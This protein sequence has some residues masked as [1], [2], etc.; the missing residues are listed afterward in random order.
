M[1]VPL[2][3]SFFLRKLPFLVLLLIGLLHAGQAQNIRYVK[4]GAT[5]GGASW[6][7]ASGDI[8]LM[9]N[10]LTA[11]PGGGQV[12]IAGG[13]Y[14]PLHL[15][16]GDA[17]SDHRDRAF[18]LK[19][20][21]K[22]YGGF[23]GTEQALNQRDTLSMFSA[24]RQ[25]VLSGNIRDAGGALIYIS[26]HV[27]VS[28]GDVGS[29][30]MDGLVISDG[31]GAGGGSGIIN[32]NGQEIVRG[33][34]AGLYISGSSPRV[35]RVIIRDNKSDSG[36]GGGG[37]FADANSAPVLS[38]VLIYQNEGHTGGG[39][40]S[41]STGIAKLTNVTIA[42]NKA[43]NGAGGGWFNEQSNGVALPVLKNSILHGN[44]AGAGVTGNDIDY[45]GNLTPDYTLVANTFFYHA[46]SISTVSGQVFT[47]AAVGDFTLAATS[48]AINKGNPNTTVSEA[49]HSDLYGGERKR[50]V[51]DLG[52]IE[53]LVSPTVTITPASG[54]V[55][56]T[57]QGAGNFSGNSWANATP[58]LRGAINA[59]GAQQVWV[60]RGQYL[61]PSGQS[62]SM[63]EGVKI[64][65][66]F[67]G[68]E[69]QLTQRNYTTNTT[70][71]KGNGNSVIRNNKNGLTAT[72]SLLDGFTITGGK[73]EKGG[74]IYNEK[75][76]PSVSNCIINAN[77]A[78]HGG[79]WYNDD[80]I[81]IVT[82]CVFSNNT[83]TKEGGGGY[84]NDGIGTFVNCT[85]MD[86]R[87][88]SAQEGG[89][90]GWC[91]YF[92]TTSFSNCLF[93]ENKSS[94][95]G[96]GFYNVHGNPTLS[97]CTFEKNS[98]GSS[99]GGGGWSNYEGNPELTDCIFKENSAYGGG[100]WFNYGGTPGL[101]GCYFKENT[102]KQGGGWYHQD[103]TP[104]LESCSFE[105][106][107][108]S[109]SHG[110]GWYNNTGNPRLKGCSFKENTA[111]NG[112]GWLNFQGTPTLESCNFEKNSA[113]SLVGGGGWLN[114]AGDPELI[115][116][117]FKENTA[118]GGG[119][120]HNYT[121][122]PTLRNCNF[123]KNSALG[124][125]G[126]WYNNSESP[127]LTGCT[128]K[129]NIA[130][131]G[132]G[133][134]NYNGSPTL[135]N[136][137]F[138]KNSALRSDGGGWL[139]YAGNPALE[140]C[141]FKENT[142]LY[143][144]GWYNK[145]GSPMLT[146]CT[147]RENSSDVGG[148]WINLDGTPYVTNCTFEK[149]RAVI[150]GG[151]W[152]N[153]SGSP[154]VV[155]SLFSGNESFLG[156]AWTNHAG[157]PSVTG[158]LFLANQAAQSTKGENGQ[159][160]AW[161]NRGGNFKMVNCT[162]TGNHTSGTLG[163]VL[164]D[165]NNGATPEI[166]N[167]IISGNTIGE[168]SP[169]D[170]DGWG[171]H[172]ATIR[173]SI[174]T[175]N[176]YDGI[177]TPAAQPNTVVDPITGK[178][179]DDSPAINQ[180]DPNTNTSGYAVQAGERDFF[181]NSRIKFGQID[182]GALER[183]RPFAE[184]HFP[185]NTHPDSRWVFY[186][187]KGATG[188]GSGRSFADAIPELAEALYRVRNISD[189]RIYV[190]GGEYKPYFRSDLQDVE[191]SDDRRN[192]FVVSGNQQII[193][194]FAG[195]E[196]SIT[197][198]NLTKVFSENKTIL[199]GDINPANEEDA[200]HVLIATGG[201]G[202]IDGVTILGGRGGDTS[203]DILVN[204]HT[205]LSGAG[206]GI[207]LYDA[208]P[209]IERVIVH[210]NRAHQTGGGGGVYSAGTSA[211]VV[212]NTL[213]HSNK[214][215]SGGG[216]YKSGSGAPT[217]VNTTISENDATAGSGG[218]W[219]NTGTNPVMYNSI[220]HGNTAVN[221]TTPLH[222][223]YWGS[224]VPHYTLLGTT[225]Y[226]SG[227]VTKVISGTVFNPDYTLAQGSP[228]VNTGINHSLASTHDLSG[229][230]RVR[231]YRVDLGAFEFDCDVSP[232]P[233][234]LETKTLLHAGANYLYNACELLAVVTPTGEEN[235]VSGMITA[236][237]WVEAGV[238]PAGQAR[239]VRRHY[240][241]SPVANVNP[242]SANITLFFTKED[243]KH[244]NDQYGT[245]NNARLPVIPNDDASRLRVIQYHGGGDNTGLPESYSDS[246]TIIPASVQWNG[247]I[248]LWEVTFPVTRFSGFFVTGQGNGAL[249][250]TLVNFVAEKQEGSVVLTWQTT[251]EV[252]VS[253]FELERSTDV[254]T[255]TTI[256]KLYAGPDSDE[257]KNY[258]YQDAF[259]TSGKVYYRLKIVDSDQAFDYSPIRVVNFGD[260]P[261]FE[262]TLY[263]NPASNRVYLKTSGVLS[264]VVVRDLTGR[265]IYRS[266]GYDENGIELA[267]SWPGVLLVE[268]RYQ[269]G[270]SLVKRLVVAR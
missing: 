34:G 30:L 69:T 53:S 182:I 68:T 94:R 37:V 70:I 189:A 66:G 254:R 93:K 109:E 45:L 179:P 150:N 229:R 260:S 24:G 28:A 268:A 227:T 65:G 245:A 248:D 48:P 256:G 209:K 114:Y 232:A 180:G 186:V 177:G 105:K 118:N 183:H 90:G 75:V 81:S 78:D 159:G 57:T 3:N 14:S 163:A 167:S 120:W 40:Y 21:V 98:G 251:S 89:G 72:G 22:L 87:T 88:M 44:S 135:S 113:T 185:N 18:S 193:G 126:G 144:G 262:L 154:V 27:V 92:G 174:L 85:F 101:R 17:I 267:S 234:L 218:G 265:I 55:Y 194:G 157:S 258:H 139:N 172:T 74:G 128:F 127:K 236:K 148:A 41:R 212:A 243:F 13:T 16:S 217:L 99:S 122:V 112:G 230:T 142:A 147:F 131:N 171:L 102:A 104:T 161:F 222:T 206:A 140:G 155:N 190:A 166:I 77:Q 211:P 257:I 12:W 100:G 23:V 46:G 51:I 97:H 129:E 170:V 204:G 80:G 121:G 156:G 252:N 110:G 196:T 2:F 259:F 207:A 108:A 145:S 164:N 73:A 162:V 241:L 134:F 158:S 133:W 43:L 192:S 198:R 238:I 244:Y 35:N 32:V 240:D 205:V 210:D 195:T 31:S 213:I 151:A 29:A 191:R 54:V 61:P 255:W 132:G 143:G 79:G 115:D 20:D 67:A 226:S 219:Y 4:A 246:Y 203:G 76:S 237:N 103:G 82:N 63:K 202:V 25:T 52:A 64:Y 239:F 106:N 263:P 173:Y 11:L 168:G 199:S 137:N 86:N 15:P 270:S 216:W 249:P 39:W 225:F 116:C 59:V 228:V 47:N 1:Q 184:L 58:D 169:N 187:K 181:G 95:H 149:N 56:V 223:D 123:E 71:L 231:E 125:G 235:P 152:N 124:S 6:S 250:V 197:E 60:A 153:Q 36:Y 266:P 7:N 62:F 208:S 160:A 261:G 84:A 178:L 200:Y 83:A 130:V 165:P 107:S 91:N 269:D 117:H 176:R 188:N 138:E 8:Q 220:I 214:A 221:A 264:E 49:G 224:L 26:Y 38:N 10:Q 9:I 136:C 33:R 111:P 5:G 175:K 141:S 119:G 42:S 19:K 247:E 96:G 201:S 233:H 242:A 253:H 146:R 50:A 215:H